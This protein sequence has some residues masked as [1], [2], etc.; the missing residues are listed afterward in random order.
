MAYKTNSMYPFSPGCLDHR[1]GG[2]VLRALAGLVGAA[3]FFVGGLQKKWGATK[4]LLF[5]SALCLMSSAAW[6]A[7]LPGATLINTTTAKY[8]IDGANYTETAAVALITDATIQFMAAT[9]GGTPRPV[10]T[11]MCAS[12]GAIGAPF[13]LSGGLVAG[14]VALTPTKSYDRGQALYIEATDHSINQNP[15]LAETVVVTITSGTGTGTV[16]EDHET[17]LLTETGTDTGVFMA[18]IKTTSTSASDYNCMLSFDVFNAV[19]TYERSGSSVRSVTAAALVD[20]YNVVFDGVSGLPVDGAIVTLVNADTG[21]L[22]VVACYDGI[23][24][25]PNPIVTGSSFAQC[26]DVMLPSGGYTFPMLLP[27]NYALRVELPSG[28]SFPSLVPPGSL[29]TGFNIVGSPGAG[30]SY[31]TTFLITPGALPQRIDIP[32]DQLG[33]DLQITKSAGKSVVGEGEYAPYTLT[34]GNIA[35]VNAAQNVRIAD[36]LPHGFRYQASSARLNAELHPDPMISADGRTLTFALGDIPAADS[37][38]LKYVAQ[39]TAG[40]QA[41]KAENIAVSVGV[42]TSNTARA[43]VIVREDLMR[44]RAILMGRVIIGSCDERVDNDKEGLQNALIMLEDGTSILTDRDGRWHADNIRPGTHVVQLDLDSLPVNYEVVTCEENSRFA[45]RNYSQFVNVRGGSLWRA[46]FHVQEKVPKE[47]RFTQRLAAQRDDDVVQVKLELRGAGDVGLTSSTLLLP[48]GVK[49]VD[50]SPRLDGKASDALKSSDGFLTLRLPQEQG[51]WARTLTLDLQ[52]A[53]QK[54]LKLVVMTRFVAP[55]TNKNVTLPQAE[56][57]VQVDAEPAVVENFSLIPRPVRLANDTKAQAADTDDIKLVEQLP[58]DADWLASARPGTEWLHPQETFLPALPAIKAAVKL[59]AGQRATLKLNG[60]EVDPLYYDGSASNA[61]RSVMLATWRGIHIKAGDNLME[62]VVRDAAGKEVLHQSRNIHY[63]LSPDRFEFLPE[64]SRLIADGKTRP[65]IA[66]R[67]LDKD[68]HKMRRGVNG[69]YQ[70]NSPYQSAERLDAILRDPL[71]GNIGGQPRFE[72]GQE[73]IALL[74]LEPTTQSGEVV[75]NVNFNNGREQELRAWLEAGQRD[76]ILVG[77]AEGALGHEQ[78]SGNLSAVDEQGTDAQLFEGNR[79]AFYAKGTVKGEY[80][81]TIAYDSAKHRGAA[82]SKLAN[83]NQAIDPNL[84]YTLYADANQPTFDAAS[85]SKLYLKIE[86]KQFYALFGDYDTGLIATEFSRYSRTVTGLK[87]EYKGKVVGYTAFAT[88]TAQ[89]YVRDEIPGDGTSGLYR[90]TRNNILDNSDKI[91]IEVRERFQSQNIVSTQILTRYLDYD[92]D[93]IN[94]TLFFKQPINARDPAFNPVLIVAEYESGDPSDESLTAGGRVNF[95]LGD[96]LEVGATLVRDGTQGGSGNLQGLDAT[97][98]VNDAI[99]IEA[100]FARSEREI[101]SLDLDGD[102]WKVEL[103]HRDAKVYIREQQGGFGIGQQAGS[104]SD[105]RKAGAE[106][107]MNV[108]D[109]FQVQGEIY[110]DQTLGVVEAQ[111]DV[112]E[113]RFNHFLGSLTAYYGARLASDDDGLGG[114][115]ESK[116]ALAGAGYTLPGQKVTL[117]ADTEIS[118]GEAGSVDFPDRVQLGAD[119]N[120][121]AQTKLFVEQ[122]FA[123]GEN[124]TADMTSAGV[125]TQLWNGGEMSTSL[126]KQNSLDSGRIYSNLGLVQKWQVNEFWNTDFGINRA[127]E[128]SNTGALPLNPNVPLASGAARGDYTAVS[129]GANYNHPVW[130]ANSGL[131]LRTSDTDDKINFRAGLRRTLDAGRVLASSII[132]TGCRSA[133]SQ[134]RKVNARFSYAH[135]P[136]DSTWIWLDRLDYI[137]ESSSDASA[138]SH[139]RKLVNNFNANWMAKRGTQVALQYGSKY[140]L[141]DNDGVSNRGYTDLAG[142]ELRHDLNPDWD[143]GAHASML[144]TWSGGEKSY[145]LGVSLGYKLMDNTWIATGYNLLGFDD[146]DFSGAAYRNQG[147]YIALRIKFDQDTMKQLKDNWLLTSAP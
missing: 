31:G 94:G 114:T 110:R 39:V 54:P 82:G 106:L 43:S 111:R 1:V 122:E 139:A 34:I 38:M 48:D 142:L 135:R 24:A 19:Y 105:T 22:A 79:L 124:I 14:S 20:P 29:P 91:R 92:I 42:H 70:L 27:G 141:D 16:P 56:V 75:L 120:L 143:I 87:S 63:T 15:A 101:S 126:G 147:L 66:L 108:S 5:A 93:Y 95:T 112:L 129:V 51:V 140:V 13:D 80:L 85:T 25:S 86:R 18:A 41:G 132:Y 83:L 7:A 47:I 119:Y 96:K 53:D 104:E 11:S 144:R 78:L 125:R 57:Q 61:K 69:E 116:Q 65:I 99:K 103:I 130:G 23:N 3:R 10:G 46:D 137:D 26:G 133:V 128:L 17:L 136:W 67:F 52:P 121:S 134:S 131:E 37:I 9:S 4:K 145:G 107:R 115:R 76:W 113:A 8:T 98:Q 89:A 21:L 50:G 97:W 49:L 123:R 44:S 32:V 90:L 35:T 36:R 73:G 100:E 6:T 2:I 62:L 12:S 59:G 118:F 77:F 117:R 60:K 88:M 40:A 127:Q 146:A 138:S 30:A 74:E 68:G 55:S 33:G 81:M 102:A 64:Y 109:T 72:I 71:A 84:Y 58:Y 28:Y 45:G